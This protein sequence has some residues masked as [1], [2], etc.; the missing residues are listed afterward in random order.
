MP[1][2]LIRQRVADYEEWKRSFAEQ[3]HARTANGC[4]DAHI[5][6]NP[7]DPNEMIVILIWDSLVRARL[8]A[9]SDDLLDALYRDPGNHAPE[10]WLLDDG[11]ATTF[12]VAG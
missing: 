12:G 4:H 11:S 3:A 9:Q 6:R 8:F 2:L 10:I 5:Y 1:A 7:D